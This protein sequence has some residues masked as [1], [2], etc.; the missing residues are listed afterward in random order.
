MPQLASIVASLDSLLET[1]RFND[2]ALNGLQVEAGCSE[3]RRIAFAVDSG[4]SVIESAIKREANLLVVHHGLFWSQAQAL[5]GVLGRKIELLTRARMA[6]YASHLPLDAH[7][8]LGNAAGLAH[9]FE[10]ENLSSDFEYGGTPIGVIANCREVRKLDYFVER[11]QALAPSP[12]LSLAHG[13]AKI[14]KVGIV[15]GSGAFGIDRAARSGCD[16]FIS[17]EPKQQV[18]HETKELNLNALFCG[19]Y[20][21]ETFGVRALSHK[22]ARDFDVQ[23][24]FIDEP[25]GI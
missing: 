25:T 12:I 9:F 19:H 1:S 15:T 3:V 16:L 21:T 10:L 5:C 4:V 23:V 2:V 22:L 13:K 18:Y 20:A 14:S 24:D 6:L 11:A 8:E 17:G 7:L